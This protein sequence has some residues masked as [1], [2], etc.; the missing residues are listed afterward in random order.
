[1]IIIL[2]FFL[3]LNYAMRTSDP[4][5]RKYMFALMGICAAIILLVNM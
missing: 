4:K 3:V 1:M 5:Y 2:K